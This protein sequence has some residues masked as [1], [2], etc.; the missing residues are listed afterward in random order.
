MRLPSTF[1][2][3]RKFPYATLLF[4]RR[5]LLGLVTSSQNVGIC[6][7]NV[8]PC[9]RPEQRMSALGQMRTLGQGTAPQ[10]I[11]PGALQH[12]GPRLQADLTAAKRVALGCGLPAHL[13]SRDPTGK[14]GVALLSPA[15]V[16]GICA[17]ANCCR[18]CRKRIGCPLWVMSRHV[19]CKSSCP[20]C[21]QK[22]TWVRFAGTESA[23]YCVAQAHSRR[24][25]TPIMLL[26]R[27]CGG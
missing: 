15:K 27:A 9:G 2:F 10:I 13:L 6:C 22:R 11:N 1:Q 24:M 26:Y 4:E 3:S 12:R 16:L 25:L 5:D 18:E 7:H 14:F 23:I 8:L 17:T 21:P 19:Q 20:L